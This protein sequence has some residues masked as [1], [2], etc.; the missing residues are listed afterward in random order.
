MPMINQAPVVAKKEYSTPVQEAVVTTYKEPAKTP[1]IETSPEPA[2]V[3]VVATSTEPAKAPAPAEK[4]SAF[5]FDTVVA[6]TI[7]CVALFGVYFT[8]FVRGVGGKGSGALTTAL[9]ATINREK[10]NVTAHTWLFQDL[11]AHSAYRMLIAL[12]DAT[13]ADAAAA[14]ASGQPTLAASLRDEA[15]NYRTNAEAE[16]G[17]FSASYV[18]PDNTFDEKSFLDHQIRFES[19]N[20][21]V[22]P[23]GLFKKA[24]F[25]FARR[26]ELDYAL[27]GIGATFL[28]LVF[29][30]R[31]K[32]RIRYTWYVV[33]LLCFASSM[34]F[35]LYIANTVG[36]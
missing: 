14:E 36:Y 8:G 2:K 21:I 16:T 19:R 10:A 18:L 20:R 28:F 27:L 5:T 15:Q 11:R 3:P 22:N 9:A 32:T 7:A 13:E 33:A 29:S 26:K 24:E 25:Q 12:A 1:V 4:K 31:I 6:L 30:E 35:V 23:A 17:F 34:G